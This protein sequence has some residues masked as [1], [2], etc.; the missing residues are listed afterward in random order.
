[1][2]THRLLHL[3]VVILCSGTI[4]KETLSQRIR[5]KDPSLISWTTDIHHQN[6]PKHV[7]CSCLSKERRPSFFNTLLKSLICY[8]VD[9]KL[10]L[11]RQRRSSVPPK[12]LTKLDSRKRQNFTPIAWS[13]TSLIRD[14]ATL[15]PQYQGI[16]KTRGTKRRTTGE[17]R[18]A[19]RKR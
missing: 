15:L 16:F 3:K 9:V 5:K 19:K 4:Y 1:M 17:R 12:N 14:C 10:P 11:M 7:L 8:V 13:W 6:T 2:T 18:E